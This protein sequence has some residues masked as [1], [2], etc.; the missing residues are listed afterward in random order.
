MEALPT[1]P[2]PGA[3]CSAPPVPTG[4]CP[5]CPRLAAEFEPWRQAAW[6]RGMH[7]RA[8]Q[9]EQRLQQENQTLRARIRDL[10]GRLFGRR[11]EAV[12][13]LAEADP[14]PPLS[15][16]PR[17]RGQQRGRPG[18]KRRDHSHLPA[19]E[20]SIDLP[21]DERQC[22]QCGQAFVPFPGT[23]D[24]TVL[25]VEVRAHRRLIR[26]RRYRPACRCG[27][28]PG[29]VTAPPP[30]KVLPKSIL[31]VSIWVRVLLDK[32][33]F[34]RPTYR[35]LAELATEGLDLSL[36]TITDGLRR[37]LPLLEPLYDALEERSRVQT[38]WHADETRW[39]VYT[40]VEGKVGY[41][42]FLWVFHASDVVVFVLAGGRAHDVPEEH[43]G[44]QAEGILVVDRHAAYK[45]LPQVKE[46]RIVLAF[47]WAHVRRD[48]LEA[49]RAWPPLRGWALSWVDRIGAL[50]R[51]NDARRVVRDDPAAFAQA[52]QA[53]RQQI[54]ALVRQ[55]E[56]ELGEDD[57]H[58]ARRKTLES[59]QQHW[60][61]LTVFVD[62]PDVPMDNNTAERAQ[63]G[64]VV[65]RKNYYG[66]GAEWAGRLAA[67]L[68][69]LLQT[70]SLANLNPRLWLTAYLE[71]C[72]AA[73]GRAP[74][75]ATAY[76]PW[77]LTPEQKRAWRYPPPPHNSS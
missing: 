11:T 48:F 14:L 71:A 66:S 74:A 51:A 7:Q 72:A 69:S 50:Y 39:L 31:G 12:A 68:F 22:P 15:T 44:P 2:M 75:N 32:Y 58:T 70:L 36:G 49:A 16:P 65:G 6:W 47:C 9:R 76:L 26:R 3:A 41:R 28:N 55:R 42:W 43:L 24:S 5:V 62:H 37:L 77:N 61:G 63:R 60:P 54:A 38:L 30:P 56:I 17:P 10:E 33:L 21:S 40:S 13:V 57:L 25:E 35:L 52:D 20:E 53:L 59:L 27:C 64:P 34:Y 23:D 8:V 29:I 4:P 1:I 67:L 45:A 18:P 19:V 73:G 46:G